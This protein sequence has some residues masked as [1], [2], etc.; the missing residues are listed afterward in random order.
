MHVLQGHVFK[1][2]GKAG[3]EELDQTDEIDVTQVPT[4]FYECM[5]MQVQHSNKR[6]W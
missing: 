4:L 2:K 3:P 5:N 1:G 6:L